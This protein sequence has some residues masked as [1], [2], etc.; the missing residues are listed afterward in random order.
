MKSFIEQHSRLG[1]R[2]LADEILDEFEFNVPELEIEDYL[3]YYKNMH[4]GS[5]SS[6]PLL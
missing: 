1:D 6:N 5:Y 3:S 4:R 2:E